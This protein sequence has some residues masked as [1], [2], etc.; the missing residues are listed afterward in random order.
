VPGTAS[1][2]TQHRRALLGRLLTPVQ[3]GWK[4]PDSFI[5]AEESTL[6]ALSF[7]WYLSLLCLSFS[8]VPGIH[9][10]VHLLE[11]FFVLV[12]CTYRTQI[13]QII[14]LLSFFDFVLQFAELFEFFNIWR[15]LSWRGVS[16]LVNWVNA[17]WDSTS[18]WVNAKWDSM[19]TESTRNDKIF[20]N[21]SVFWVDSVYTKSHSTLT[22]LTWSLI[23][24]WLSWRRVWLCVDSVWSRWIKPK[25]A[26]I[27]S[28][29]TFKGIGFRKIKNE[30]FK[31]GQCQPENVNSFYIAWSKKLTL[32]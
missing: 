18:H 2:Q 32:R 15:W 10:K 9:L 5:A 28:S 11:I 14:R 6:C 20:V 4:I 12:F 13:G 8:C 24:G 23:P 26:Y 30:M 17:K 31:W 7:I 16:F 19:S 25:Q 3:C 29:G 1:G 21:V 22:Q 27:T